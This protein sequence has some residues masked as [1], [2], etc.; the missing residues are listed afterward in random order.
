MATM[1]LGRT[2]K[3]AAIRA[4]LSHPVI[5]T[6]GHGTEFGPLVLDYLKA[7]GAACGRLTVPRRPKTRLTLPPHC[8]P[9]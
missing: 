8:C 5:D 6:D 3:S 2:T 4:R 7:A 1:N 9:A